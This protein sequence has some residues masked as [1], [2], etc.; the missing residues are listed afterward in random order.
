MLVNK[1]VPDWTW[2]KFCEVTGWSVQTPLNWFQEQGWKITK[3]AG[4]PNSKKLELDKP[5]RKH[6]KPET[7]IQLEERED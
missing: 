1:K 2:T 7:K 6:T 4:R 3:I 5:V